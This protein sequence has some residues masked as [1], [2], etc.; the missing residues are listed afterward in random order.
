V[1]SASTASACDALGRG[2]KRKLARAISAS[3]PREPHTSRA[4][5]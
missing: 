5:S 3:R 4:R 1:S 2:C